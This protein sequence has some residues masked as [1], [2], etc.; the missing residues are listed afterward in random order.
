VT[1]DA[2]VRVGD[3]VLVRGQMA[4]DKDFGYG[5]EYEILVENASVTIETVQ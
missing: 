4:I 5:Y 3:V 2:V 1:T